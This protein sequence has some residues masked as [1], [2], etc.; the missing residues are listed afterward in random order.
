VDATIDLD[1]V[2]LFVAVAETGSF[3]A[4]AD[5]LGVSKGTVSR[6]IARLE[7]RVGAP[8]LHRT[9]RRVALST[10]GAAL[11]ER[12]GPH[13]AA[14][15]HAVGALPEA[16]DEPS[17]E[18]RITAPTDLGIVLLPE[19]VARFTIRY[20]AVRVDVHLTQRKVDLVAEGFDLAIRGAGGRLKDSSLA[21]RRLSPADF[22]AYASPV[23]VA[24]RGSPREIGDADHDWVVFRPARRPLGFPASLRPRIA[25]D[26]FFFARESIK[27]GAGVGVLPTFVGEPLAATGE[28]VRVLPSYRVRTSGFVLLYP[29]R[30]PVAR[31]VA[32]F[33]DVLLELLE[34]RPLVRTR[35]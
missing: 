16:T 29:S 22:V 12:T 9:T 21:M 28:L 5:R 25:C 2:S 1:L 8:L 6:R 31:K 35:S 30:G 4:V 7:R 3:S 24:R 26:D 33:R 18:L 34:T 14:L 23:Y 17:G 15:R 11:L 20:P 32:A 19:L 27:I 13:L 10:A